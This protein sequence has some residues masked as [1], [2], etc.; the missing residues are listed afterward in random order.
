MKWYGRWTV[1]TA[2]LRRMGGYDGKR[3]KIYAH[4]AAFCISRG[5]ALDY[6]LPE[7]VM[8]HSCDNPLCCNP[9]HVSLGTQAENVRDM[10]SKGRA[11]Y[12]TKYEDLPV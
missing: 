11:R 3:V 7:N 8:L 1:P 2:A 4:R 12:T 6:L 5:Y 10:H 9:A